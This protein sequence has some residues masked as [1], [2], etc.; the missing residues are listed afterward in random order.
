MKYR[1]SVKMN[2]FCAEKLAQNRQRIRKLYGRENEIQLLKNELDNV[3]Q[4]RRSFVLLHG[5]QGQGK[6]SLTLTL[7]NPATRQGALF[8]HFSL[9]PNGEPYSAIKAAIRQL[10]N[11]LNALPKRTG[12]QGKTLEA[13][14]KLIAQNLHW[15]LNLLC[16]VIPDLSVLSHQLTRDRL[17]QNKQ[18]TKARLRNYS[19]RS[20][21]NIN[22]STRMRASACLGSHKNLATIL[23]TEEDAPLK[24][25]AQSAP[26]RLQFALNRLMNVLSSFLPIIMVCE[27][28]PLADPESLRLMHGF[29]TDPQNASLM[30]LWTY[31][32]DL[33]SLD[34]PFQDAVQQIKQQK[35]ISIQDIQ[36]QDPTLQD[37]NHM[38]AD[39]LDEPPDTT[40]ELTETIYHKTLGNFCYVMQYLGSLAE[41]GH[42]AYNMTTLKWSWDLESVRTSLKATKSVVDLM[43]HKL[44]QSELAQRLLPIAACLGVSFQSWVLQE[45]MDGIQNATDPEAIE[46]FSKVMGTTESGNIDQQL[47]KLELQGLIEASGPGTYT[48]IHDQ[49]MEGALALVGENVNDLKFHLGCILCDRMESLDQFRQEQIVFLVVDLINVRLESV[50]A[51]RR[52]TVVEINITWQLHFNNPPSITSQPSN[53][54]LLITGRACTKKVYISTPRLLRPKCAVGNTSR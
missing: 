53:F 51:A 41:R 3:C 32:A 27:D 38:I 37:V 9:N 15:E 36:L 24:G 42:L 19:T 23:D 46:L 28:A 8:V 2:Q 16:Q 18:K 39:L 35:D 47:A 1:T 25:N 45:I 5:A 11:Q 34:D 10:C 4:G 17:V 20:F 13:A 48:I 12:N 44:S 52:Q 54:C 29:V 43:K 14:Q 7:Q 6:K 26:H 50:P 21:Y 33:V 49:V 22:T 40:F 31:Q 30:L